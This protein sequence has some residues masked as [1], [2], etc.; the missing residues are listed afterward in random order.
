MTPRGD[1]IL[2]LM[3]VKPVAA[4]IGTCLETRGHRV[5][6]TDNPAEALR[7]LSFVR[8]AAVIVWLPSESLDEWAGS[9]R[10]EGEWETPPLVILSW[11]LA[12]PLAVA[13]WFVPDYDRVVILPMSAAALAGAVETACLRGRKIDQAAFGPDEHL[14]ADT[15]LRS[16]WSNA[17]TPC[18]AGRHWG[19]C[20]ARAQP[21]QHGITVRHHSRCPRTS[22]PAIHKG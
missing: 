7:V 3:E 22:R 12:N 20:D 17:E 19:E 16:D 2:V 1:D 18:R 14:L 5:L 11:S 15:G 10:G 8:P 4:W 13:S 9:L 6:K 21:R